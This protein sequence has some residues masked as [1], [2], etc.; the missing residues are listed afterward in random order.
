LR[1]LLVGSQFALASFLV[2]AV[3]VLF[4]QRANLRETLLGRFSDQYVI[5]SP[6][7]PGGNGDP[8]VLATELRKAVGIKGITGSAFPPWQFQ[9]SRSR[10]SLSPGDD[11]PM[12]TAEPGIVGYDYF[13]VLDIPL[14][15]GRVF[16]R[17]RNDDIGGPAANLRTPSAAQVAVLDRNA[18][19]AFGWT[20]PA[21]AIGKTIYGNNGNP[22]AATE[23]IGVVESVPIAVRD[24]GSDGIVYLLMPRL[25]A[26]TIVRV[27]KD[28]VKGAAAHID[29]VFKS[30][31][32]TGTP[33]LRQFLD[34]A[35]ESAYF[36]FDLVNRVFVALG[37][38][39][40]A[41]AAVGLFGM[42]SY[43]TS[44]RTREIGLRKTQGATSR[45]ILELLL[46]DFSKPVLVANLVVWPFAFYAAERY[47]D[48]FAQRMTLGPWPFFV[49]LLATLL[50]ACLAVG[51]RVLRASRLR[52]TEALR[53]E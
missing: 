11:Q 19:R 42:A 5:V 6:S 25:T 53:E 39:A 15:A 37:A 51:S 28:E 20:Q 21:D 23:V 9:G 1:T 31:S 18:T 3:V 10:Y 17:E 24:R 32:P 12:I 30:L 41:I 13:D 29:D 43:M 48:N 52:P 34:Q 4:S 50:V 36:T 35:F 8:N 16:A 33:P 7:R 49:A 46:W 40:I 26:F 44:R 22:A 27:D 38:F 2:V 47:L 14:L 45:Q